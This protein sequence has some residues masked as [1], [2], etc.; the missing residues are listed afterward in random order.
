[1]HSPGNGKE[2]LAGWLADITHNS[3]RLATFCLGKKY[4]GKD[5]KYIC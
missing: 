5:A 2:E 4:P 3:F 1:M